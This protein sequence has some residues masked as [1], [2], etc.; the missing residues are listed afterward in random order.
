MRAVSDLRL[1]CAALFACACGG[2]T[3]PEPAPTDDSEAG[4][5][6]VGAEPSLPLRTWIPPPSWDELPLEAFEALVDAELPHDVVT[7][8]PKESV[9]ELR[10]AL[11]AMDRRSLRAAV[12]LAR[13]RSHRTAEALLARLEQRVAGPRRDS[14]AADCVG[15]AALARFPFPERYAERVAALAVGPRPHPDLEVR[16]E[17]AASALAHGRDEVIPFLLKVLRI[18]TPAGLEDRRDFIA[19]PTTAWPRATAA[20]ALSERAG[21][22]VSYQSDAPL[23]HR[24][25]EAALLAAALQVTLPIR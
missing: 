5:T 15:A 23:A 1:L 13:S 24:E 19:S 22:P 21:L 4:R 16:V 10:R 25:R 18:D 12:L 2:R 8:F 11:D 20:R 9:S 14:D 7:R 6:L 3:A 17:C